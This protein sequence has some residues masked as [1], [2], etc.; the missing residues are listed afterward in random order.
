MRVPSRSAISGPA[1]NGGDLRGREPA[2][3]LEMVVTGNGLPRRH[4]AAP[5]HGCDQSRAFPRVLV[6]GE[7]KRR[8]FPLV[9]AGRA[10]GVKG[11]R[12]VFGISKG[13]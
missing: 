5:H 6:T 4:D 13:P 11:R 3:V 9:V 10:F 7:R 2:F 12:Y 8:D 1:F